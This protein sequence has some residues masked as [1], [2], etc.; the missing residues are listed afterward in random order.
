MSNVS[1]AEASRKWGVARSV[2]Y[3]DMNS[4][5]LSYTLDEKEKRVLDP[6]ELVRVY[7]EPQSHSVSRSSPDASHETTQEKSVDSQVIDAYKERIIDLKDY[8]EV[9]KSQLVEKDSQVQAL[10]SQLSETTQRLLPSPEPEPDQFE[11][12]IVYLDLDQDPPKRKWWRFGRKTESV[13]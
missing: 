3:R 7:G 4:G 8:I 13:D 9:L 6:T 5:K 11:E 1:P 10:M 12:D 2:M